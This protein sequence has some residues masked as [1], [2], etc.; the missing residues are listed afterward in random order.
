MIKV[1]VVFDP[2]GFTPEKHGYLIE[3]FLGANGI[4]A[5]VVTTGFGMH[6]MDRS[7]AEIL[8]I[9]YG[10]MSICGSGDV[11]LRQVHEAIRWAD[12]HPGGLLVI[13]SDFTASLYYEVKEGFK[14]L[15]NVVFR[16]GDTGREAIEQIKKW[17]SVI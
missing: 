1:A 3:T 7:D 9:D 15:D 6:I 12:E 5:K 17:A 10:G 4:E 8:V 13:W 11:A 16:A 14:H 2:D